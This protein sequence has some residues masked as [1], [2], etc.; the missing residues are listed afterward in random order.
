MRLPRVRF[1]VRRVSVAVGLLSI[2]SLVAFGAAASYRR[3]KLAHARNRAHRNLQHIAWALGA[4]RAHRR[5]LP[6]GTIPNSA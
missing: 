1:T 2:L 6:P 3:V 4:Y 5:T